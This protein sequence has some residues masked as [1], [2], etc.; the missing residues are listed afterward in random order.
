MSSITGKVNSKKKKG[1]GDR[2]VSFPI[3]WSKEL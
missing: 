1:G 2:W 3:K